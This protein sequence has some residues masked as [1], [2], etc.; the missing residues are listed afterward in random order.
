MIRVLI[1]DD[2]PGV[3]DSLKSVVSAQDDMDVCGEASSGQEA[4]Q[5]LRALEPHVIL[6][7]VS[8]PGWSGAT[9]T[10]SVIGACPGVK[11]IALSRHDD[12]S[13][14]R[15]MF[16]AGVIAFIRKQDAGRE[17]VDA[18]RRVAGDVCDAAGA[19]ARFTP[20]ANEGT[21]CGERELEVPLTEGE[22]H[23]LRLV[24]TAFS[25]QRI[26]QRMSISLDD[27]VALKARA[28]GKAGLSSRI[29]VITYAR[30]RGWID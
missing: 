6:M 26:G 29:Q 25:N 21:T 15:E 22:Q 1:V 7:D 19:D 8:M 3:R 12:P 2:H 13:I 5:R 11:I 23:V 17:L 27:V 9:T 24:A 16:E 4:L 28:M 10:R 14:V 30:R 18:I 20:V